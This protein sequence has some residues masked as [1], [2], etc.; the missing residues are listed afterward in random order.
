MAAGRPFAPLARTRASAKP[1][2][3]TRLGRRSIDSCGCAMGAK[4]MAVAFL[5]AAALY[6]WQFQSGETSLGGAVMRVLAVTFI[7]TG[8]GKTFGIL[9]HRWRGMS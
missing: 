1:H 4:F 3:R 2:R 5:V 9:R 6:A 8:V 7:A